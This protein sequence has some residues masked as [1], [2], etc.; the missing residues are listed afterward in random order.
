MSFGCLFL[1]GLLLPAGSASAL[2]HIARGLAGARLGA[3]RADVRAA[4]G[5]PAK[6]KSGSNDF[7]RY[8]LYTYAGGIRVTFQGRRSVTSVE[9]T[10]LGDR[11]SR[12]IGVGSAE[13][14]VKARVRGVRCETFASLRSCHTGN[15][16][17][18]HRVTDFRIVGG[19]V[20]RV[21]VGVVID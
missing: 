3:S 13:A 14:A 10:G 12:G 11:T 2:I 15:L 19:K 17:A 7:G 9:T 21:V 4:L 8:V 18:G 20:D 6:V 1:A 5:K 16:L